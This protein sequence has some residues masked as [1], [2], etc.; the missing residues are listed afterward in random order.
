[1][2]PW[3]TW[4]S[5]DSLLLKQRLQDFNLHALLVGMHLKSVATGVRILMSAEWLLLRSLW[6]RQISAELIRLLP[7]HAYCT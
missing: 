1:M 6:Q 4:A 2:Y 5:C 7:F 3:D